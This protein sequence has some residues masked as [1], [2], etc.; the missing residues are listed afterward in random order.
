MK[1]PALLL[2][3]V[4]VTAGLLAYA[5][6]PS[7]LTAKYK[8]QLLPVVRV[9]G[10]EA[11]VMVNGKEVRI[12]SNPTYLVQDAESFSDNF[13]TATKGALAGTMKIQVMGD[14]SDNLDLNTALSVS[15]DFS[16]QLTAKNDLKGGYAVLVMYATDTFAKPPAH[17]TP[18]QA[19]V[20]ELPT[21]P[22]GQSVKFKFF[23]R[24]VPRTTEPHFFVQIYDGAGKEVRTNYSPQVWKYYGMRD[25]SRF[26]PELEKYVAQ[27][28]GANHAAVPAITPRPLFGPAA[29][30]PTGEVTITLTVE[31][32]GTVSAVDAGM[33]ANDSARDSIIE[34]MGS[35]LF[36]P[37]LRAGEPVSTYVKVPLQF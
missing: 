22:A 32:D 17:A 31:P 3:F 25:R 27:N 18:P 28:H 29:V 4:S 37:K 30:L 10:T 9:E 19:I 7:V 1:L 15:L 20:H 36:L 23:A 2:G 6:Y 14:H 26:D 5:P 33:V 11:F 13:V 34:A 24:R 8:D 35:W 12:R 21:L 16:V